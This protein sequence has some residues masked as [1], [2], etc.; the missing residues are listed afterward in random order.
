ME[1]SISDKY[2]IITPLSPKI[3]N[4]DIKRLS[5]IINQCKNFNIGLDMSTVK[6]CTI[7]FF[8]NI[9]K[10]NNIS[11]FNIPSDIFVILTIMKLDKTINLYVTKEDFIKS[12][13]R[14]LTR[15]LKS[16]K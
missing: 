8:E 12:Y 10:F 15:N 16:I 3:Q 13:H 9:R 11:L 6:D 14:V 5:D 7:D 4:S 1:I 2:C